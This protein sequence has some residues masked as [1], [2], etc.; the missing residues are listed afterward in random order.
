[1]TGPKNQDWNGDG[2]LNSGDQWIE[3]F[4]GSQAPVDLSA[5]QLRAVM[6]DTTPTFIFPRGISIPAQGYLALFRSQ[7]AL[8]VRAPG[9]L[10]LLFPDGTLADSVAFPLLRADRS[11]GRNVD[12]A[13]SW[14]PDCEPSPAA[15]NC[16]KSLPAG[17]NAAPAGGGFLFFRVHIQE[18]GT[19]FDNA[20]SLVT[21]TLITNFLLAMILA[22]A[23]GFFGNLLND[24]L[25]SNEKVILERLKPLRSAVQRYRQLNTTFQ[26][27]LHGG[28][29]SWLVFLL[30]LVVVLLLYGFI[31]A[32]LDP[33][34]DLARSEGWLLILTLA[35]SAG[36][37][38]VID[39]VSQYIYLRSHGEQAALRVHP[40]N[41][42]VVAASTLISRGVG[43]TPGILA[44]SPAG[45]EEVKSGRYET[46]LH[47]LAL[48]SVAVFAL[49][50]WLAAPFAGD[51]LWLRT[52]LLVMFAVGVQTL[53]FE[54][55][56]LRY[57]HGRGIFDFNR[58]VWAILFI[59]VS[60][61]FMQTMLNP[62][63]DF[64][65]AFDSPN[66]VI[67]SIV[68]LIFCVFSAAVWLYFNRPGKRSEVH[69]TE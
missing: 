63:G 67:L 30:T 65:K 23:M 4:N 61:L 64:V 58:G 24:T 29:L 38:G 66:I 39:D 51:N 21:K 35:L 52:L 26:A 1:M 8:D 49:A 32:F 3:L 42:I 34:F 56:P 41:L 17:I 46:Q 11:Y 9:E 45:L 19:L 22:L 40:A 13:G 12:G 14:T 54:L 7:T 10:R 37:I 43:L 44:G 69:I 18:P 27:R 33:S 60:A 5:W 48:G 50:G 55:I 53:F 36:L 15:K 59:L 20:G 47:F 28:R 62:D 16:L 25:E 31:F 2:V 57:F 68:V 6:G